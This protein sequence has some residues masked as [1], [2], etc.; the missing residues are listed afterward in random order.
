MRKLVLLLSLLFGL[1]ACASMYVDP[2]QTPASLRVHARATLD[3]QEVDDFLQEKVLSPIEYH[4]ARWGGNLQGP[5]WAIKA[6][7]RDAKGE[8]RPL[9]SLNNNF[10]EGLETYKFAG[11]RDFIIPPGQYPVEIWLEAYM[12][13]CTDFWRRDCG[14]PTVK[15]WTQALP[16]DQFAPGQQIEFNI[17]GRKFDSGKGLD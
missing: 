8:L 14:T 9:R 13:Y 7:Q 4:I 6:Y 5:W 3:P 17:D 2:G 1:S 16:F 10:F 11:Y 15:R 12:H